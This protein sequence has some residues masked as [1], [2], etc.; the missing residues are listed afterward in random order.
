MDF[1]KTSALEYT[2]GGLPCEG[3]E[4][5]VDEHSLG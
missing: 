1:L 5:R 2:H 3:F 4:L